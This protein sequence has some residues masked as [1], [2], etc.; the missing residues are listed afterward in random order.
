MLAVTEASDQKIRYDR[1]GQLAQQAN[2]AKPLTVKQKKAVQLLCAGLSPLCVADSIGIT[3]QAMQK[4][5]KLPA[6][7]QAVSEE[8][9]VDTELH[10]VRLK[11]LYGKALD[12]VDKLLDDPN[13][14]IR[15]QAARLAFEAEQNIARALEEQQALLALERRM[16]ELAQ[17]AIHGNLPSADIQDVEVIE[18]SH[19]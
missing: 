6:F 4:W 9:Q 11:A 1:S 15:L 13:P 2:K 19:S 16:E 14:H 10:G 17:A 7:R 3:T 5:R 8:M 12:R 18:E